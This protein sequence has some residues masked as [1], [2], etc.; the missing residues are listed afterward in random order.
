MNL[1]KIK[2]TSFT[3]FEQNQNCK[4]NDSVSK[5]ITPWNNIP[6]PIVPNIQKKEV[7]KPVIKV[8]EPI[9]KPKE[10]VVE[11]CI[12]KSCQNR[13]VHDKRDC[14]NRNILCE[15]CNKFG[16]SYIDCEISSCNFCHKIGHTYHNCY[17]RC[18]KEK[19]KTGIIHMYKMCPRNKPCTVCGKMGHLKLECFKNKSNDRNYN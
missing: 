14:P 9:V 10:N 17:Y 7:S 16:H 15:K 2:Y 3:N 6:V 13:S 12:L 4:E 1:R 19:C 11:N 8:N 5:S 18:N